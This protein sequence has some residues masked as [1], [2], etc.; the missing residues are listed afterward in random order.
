MEDIGGDADIADRADAAHE[1]EGQEAADE[2]PAAQPAVA[3][4]EPVV[5]ISCGAEMVI[6]PP[7]DTNPPPVRLPPELIVTN[8]FCK[9][10][11]D[12]DELGSC[13][14]PPVTAKPA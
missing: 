10:A 1:V 2:A 9:L 5:E 6:I 11:F 12:I 7:K 13:N 14:P 3:I 4:G 8:E